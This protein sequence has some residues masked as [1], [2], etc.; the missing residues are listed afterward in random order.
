MIW[1][2]K[3]LRG[4]LHH[5]IDVLFN[6]TNTG[7]SSTNVQDALAEIGN[8]LSARF[9]AKYFT[10]EY[11]GATVSG[12]T[13]TIANACQ[14]VFQIPRQSQIGVAWRM[15]KGNTASIYTMPNYLYDQDTLV[16]RPDANNDTYVRFYGIVIYKND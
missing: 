8:D 11:T 12:T 10:Y 6:N 9:K 14:N 2:G 16:F 13:Y 3:N 5:A 7:L 4:F 1:K 15:I